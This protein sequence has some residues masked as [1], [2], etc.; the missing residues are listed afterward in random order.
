MSGD[1]SDGPGSMP[2]SPEM[3]DE[4]LVQSIVDGNREAERLFA[5]RYLRPVRAMLLAR[6][7]N[8]DVAADLLQD[9]MI[10]ALCALRR[11]QL[12][13]PSKLTGFV[14]SVARNV[15]NNYFR[16]GTR[17]PESLEMPDN[18][19]DLSTSTDRVEDEER[20]S[21]AMEAIASLDP[22]DKTILQMTLVEGLKPGIIAERLRLNPDMVRQRKL[23]ATRRVIDFVRRTSQNGSISHILTGQKT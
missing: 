13:D 19:P 23:R 22:L 14:L 11:G 10:Q 18:L 20:E 15:L 12:R 7:R 17:Q 2:P 9:T 8:P 4:Q 3:D 21:L 6:S 1:H 16:T 5:G